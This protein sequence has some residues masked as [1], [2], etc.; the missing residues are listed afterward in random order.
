MTATADGTQDPYL[1][2]LNMT[3]S[4]NLKLHNKAIIGLTD[5]DMYDLTI[6]K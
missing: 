3:T 6:P 5:S 4:E 1:A 2:T